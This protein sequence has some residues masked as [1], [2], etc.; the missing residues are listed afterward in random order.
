MTYVLVALGAGLAAAVELLEALAIVLAVGTSRQW[1]DA[2][3][4]AGAAALACA[5][6]AVIVG[7]IVLA[8]VSLD[9]LRLAIGAVLLAFGLRW[10]WKNTL[11]LAGR[12]RRSSSLNE[13]VETQEELREAA[14]PRAGHADWTARVVAFRGV[15]IEGIELVLIVSAFA[16]RPSGPAPALIGAIAAFVAV[17]G[18]GIALRRPLARLPETEVKFAVAILLSSFGTFFVAEGLGVAWP[19]DEAAALYIAAAYAL[20]SLTAVRLLRRRPRRA[21]G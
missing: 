14:P 18:L 19:G 12:R 15:L 5:L 8:S 2:F 10:L 17:V 4:G 6:I 16:E 13:Y 1:R 7:P 9:T 20:A 3:I 11:R 21:S